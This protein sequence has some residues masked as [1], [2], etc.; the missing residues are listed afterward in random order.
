MIARQEAS[1]KP[2]PTTV[3]VI[4]DGENKKA[5]GASRLVLKLNNLF[6]SLHHPIVSNITYHFSRTLV[7]SIPSGLLLTNLEPQIVGVFVR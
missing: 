5:S 1:G 3:R 6:A 2:M 7:S 4:G